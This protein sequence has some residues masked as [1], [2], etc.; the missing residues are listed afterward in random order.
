MRGNARVSVEGVPTTKPERANPKDSDRFHLNVGV[1]SMRT[2]TNSITEP[3]G[4]GRSHI[5]SPYIG[6]CKVSI[7]SNNELSN[8]NPGGS[9]G[10]RY[11]Q[12]IVLRIVLPGGNRLTI[13]CDHFECASLESLE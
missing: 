9:S 4:R 5:N 3:I 11:R 12:C 2:I 13:H 6:Q 10:Y 7:P 1:G 8:R